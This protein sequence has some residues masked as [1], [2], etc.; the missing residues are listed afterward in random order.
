MN[1]GRLNDRLT[2]LCKTSHP[3]CDNSLQRQLWTVLLLSE[4]EMDYIS[5]VRLGESYIHLPVFGKSRVFEKAAEVLQQSPERLNLCLHWDRTPVSPDLT[6]T[7]LD[8]LPHINTLR[9][10]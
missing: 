9:C 6:R 10:L 4:G 8:N 5:L 3:R 1:T 2:V 7:L